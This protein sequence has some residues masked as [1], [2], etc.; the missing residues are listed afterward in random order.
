MP[1]R[2]PA[3]RPLVRA[4][5][6]GPRRRPPPARRDGAPDHDHDGWWLA[7]LWVADD[8]GVLSFQDLAPTGGP[9]PEPPLL[10]LGPTVAGNLSGMILEE[11]NR[12]SVRLGPIVPPDDPAR[13]WRVPAAIRAAFRWEPARGRRCARTNWPGPVADAFA[14]ADRGPRIAP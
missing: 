5:A 9:P 11:N 6:G 8:D 7:V 14:R 10:L 12:L 1:D 13:P 3:A 4:R 2:L